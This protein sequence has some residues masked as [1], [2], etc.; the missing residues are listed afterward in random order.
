MCVRCNQLALLPYD[1]DVESHSIYIREL[2]PVFCCICSHAC[3]VSF[4]THAR[5]A[6]VFDNKVISSYASH[7]THTRE[8]QHASTPR[9]VGSRSLISHTRASCNGRNYANFTAPLF[10]FC[11]ICSHFLYEMALSPLMERDFWC[12]PSSIS[13]YTYSSHPACKHKPWLCLSATPAHKYV[14]QQL[15]SALGRQDAP[16]ACFSSLCANLRTWEV[17]IPYNASSYPS[18]SI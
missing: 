5:V 4:H 8:L 1:L 11:R 17:I 14:L 15:F 18:F 12:E 9:Y 7:F 16:T 2:Q 6:T 10:S 3:G 13:M